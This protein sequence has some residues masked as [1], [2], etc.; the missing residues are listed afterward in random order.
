VTKEVEFISPMVAEVPPDVATVQAAMAEQEKRVKAKQSADRK[1]SAPKPKVAAKAKA[2]PKRSAP[3]RPVRGT[4]KA[5]P[6][7]I[8]AF[9][10]GLGLSNKQ[11]AEALGKSVALI[12]TVRN[13]KGDRWSRERW[14]QAK[15]R[16]VAYAKRHKIAPTA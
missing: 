7:E 11:A 15:P 9:L 14:E 5:E 2:A 10:D 1:A 13:D 12:A 4:E 16:F 8:R 3:A 6:S